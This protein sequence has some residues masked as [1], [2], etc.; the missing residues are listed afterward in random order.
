VYQVA[1]D[2][3]G[4]GGVGTGLALLVVP[5]PTVAL[6]LGEGAISLKTLVVGRVAGAALL[7]IGVTCWFSRQAERGGALGLLAGLLIYN[8]AVP[9]CSS[10]L[11]SL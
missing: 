7:S 2:R 11:P 1:A 9:L 6:L 5:S 3:D 10:T 8:L 4:L